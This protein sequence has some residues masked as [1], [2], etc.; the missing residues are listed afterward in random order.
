MSTLVISIIMATCGYGGRPEDL[1]HLQ[2]FEP[3][4]KTRC[5]TVYHNLQ[6]SSGH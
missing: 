5:S 1:T 6:R 3:A 2:E 4:V